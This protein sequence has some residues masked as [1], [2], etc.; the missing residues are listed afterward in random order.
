MEVRQNWHKF[1]RILGSL[2]PKKP[3]LVVL[4]AHNRVLA[5]AL[6]FSA[7]SPSN[8]GFS[9]V[10]RQVDQVDSTWEVLS[11]KYNASGATFIESEELMAALSQVA[12]VRPSSP[13]TDHFYAQLVRLRE[14]IG[15]DKNEKSKLAV[16]VGEKPVEQ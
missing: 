3:G 8:S 9:D 10:G 15:V 5:G 7:S 2:P 11:H 13:A 4:H 14:M 6:G 1:Q 12:S 16:H